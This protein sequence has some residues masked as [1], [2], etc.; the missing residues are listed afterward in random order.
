[1]ILPVV[2]DFNPGDGVLFRLPEAIFRELVGDPELG[3]A[4]QAGKLIEISTVLST[5]QPDDDSWDVLSS[6]MARNGLDFVECDS[7]S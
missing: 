2:E 6:C 7:G 1:M 3:R 5:A 4:S